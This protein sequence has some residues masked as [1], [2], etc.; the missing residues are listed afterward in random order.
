MPQQNCHCTQGY[1]S[2][3]EGKGVATANACAMILQGCDYGLLC[4]TLCM[5][6]SSALLPP[7]A[8]PEPQVGSARCLWPRILLAS[9]WKQQPDWQRRWRG[10]RR[11]KTS[12][13]ASHASPRDWQV[14]RSCL[15]LM[16]A[17]FT[18][19]KLASFACRAYLTDDLDKQSRDAAST[20]PAADIH[21]LCPALIAYGLTGTNEKVNASR[22]VVNARA[23]QKM[24][25]VSHGWIKRWQIGA[26]PHSPPAINPTEIDRTSAVTLLVACFLTCLLACMLHVRRQPLLRTDAAEKGAAPSG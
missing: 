3:Y 2:L 4:Y 24:Q 15:Q 18:L 9:W 6:H 12:S 25:V 22:A 10:N 16:H 5:S 1:Q 19:W 17:C 23:K 26:A 11:K 7:L 14:R 13:H 21:L 8:S 20:R